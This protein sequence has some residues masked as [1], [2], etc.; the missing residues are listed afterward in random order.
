MIVQ[1]AAQ[2][3]R[4]GVSSRSLTLEQFQQQIRQEWTIE[5]AI[6]SELGDRTV[7]VVPDTLDNP[8][9]HEPSYPIHEAL[10][11]KLTR[12]GLQ[13]RQTTY[14]ALILN[15]DGSVWQAKLSQPR[16]DRA[17]GKLYKYEMPKGSSSRAWLPKQMPIAVWQR[18][19]Q[20]HGLTLQES[21]LQQ[22]F[23]TWLIQ[24][25]QIPVILCEGA[26]KA[27]CLLSLGHAAI[28]LPGIFNGYRRATE[29]LIEDLQL[30]AAPDRPV[31]IC[32]D[33]DLKPATIENVNIA[34]RKLG[35]LLTQA[36][37]KVKILQ[38][39]GPEKGVDDFIV[40]R[41]PTAFAKLMKAALDV[42]KWNAH[43]HWE[44]SY[45]PDLTL[46][47][48][49]LGSL[50][51]PKAGF[52]FIKSAKGTGKTKALE[53]TIR[54][55]TQSGRKVLVITHRI[56]L[57]KSIC[58]Q[59]GI[60]WI[61]NL[62]ESET[63]G[64]GYGLC[65]DSLHPNSKAKFDPQDWQGA[66]V[67]FD[68]VEQVIWHALNSSTCVDRRVA[69]LETLKELLQ[70]VFASGGLVIGQDADLSDISIQYLMGLA[71]AAIAP[72]IVVNG[73]KPKQG[74]D[75]TFY[76]TPDAAPLIGKMREVIPTGKVFVCLDAQKVT[77][78]LSSTNL[79]VYLQGLFPD[80][81]IL[82]I[83]SETVSDALHPAHNL[84]DRLNEVVAQYDIVIA[85][86][87]I[88]TGISLDLQD[89][90]AA[91]FGIFHGTT[92]DSE[93]RQAL[94]RV[95]D[96]VP[97]YV[98]ANN[99][100]LGKIGN[101]SCS[102]RDL[103]RST[104]QNLR[105][106]LQLLRDFD[107]D[108]DAAYDPLTL[109]TWA[110]M[111][112]RVNA[113]LWRLRENLRSGLIA[114]GH[115]VT[116]VSDSNLEESREVKQ[117]IAQIQTEH[118]QQEAQNVAEAAELSQFDYATL[119]EQRIKIP[120]HR[121][122]EFKYKLSDRYGIPVTPELKL[123][124]DD[125]WFSKIRLHYYLLSD[126]S[127]VQRRDLRELHRH[128]ERGQHKLAPQDV[129]LLS[130]QVQTLL[131]LGIPTLLDPNLD[132]RSSDDW[133]QAIAQQAFFYRADLK[134]ILNL[135]ISDKL[136]AVCVLKSL[137]SKAGLSLR[138][139]RLEWQPEGHRT[140]V[141]RYEPPNDGREEVF[142]V[143]RQREAEFVQPLR[144]GIK[145]RSKLMH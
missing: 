21:D 29:S 95:R 80:R 41:G 46:N 113:S 119:K 112:A 64:L 48:R 82:R 53:P 43:S 134:T 16:L 40:T 92:P 63:Q 136:P 102:H 131:S 145:G 83:D 98:W 36:S 23:R 140:R 129:K 17:T 75:V 47:Q 114:E 10:N 13:A 130:A 52:A 85:T 124:D 79:E 72:W 137:L 86:P 34:I 68:E 60:D 49:Y 69:I 67:V 24:Q 108:L 18:I 5:S 74:W 121:Y 138:C 62:S 38:L 26:K 27:A 4:P 118:S 76:D 1:V 28:A 33:Y 99:F 91:V 25:T 106:N 96:S 9:T 117:A 37:C 32:F 107:F 50:P 111:A 133:V 20:Q 59:I 135:N 88:G 123:K 55:A 35:A 139:D 103:V 8:Y 22:G 109:R 12:F 11:W 65:I 126:L 66:I 132:I 122:A 93:S 115:Q 57:G 58:N 45:R 100:G 125:G 94:A 105:Y 30:L 90:F 15:D 61:E 54:K 14:A 127:W 70:V 104:T 73:W 39:P 84:T 97:R 120:A 116:C 6:D 2:D 143:W 78:R 87:T 71:E 7:E 77:S 144:P 81:R 128:L 3:T 51:F 44:L 141:Y 31:Y 110:K 42:E 101:G 56:Q 89:H 19:A 142:Q